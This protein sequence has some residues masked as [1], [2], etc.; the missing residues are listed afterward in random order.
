MKI[1]VLDGLVINPGD[2]SWQ[3]FTEFGNLEI[4]D[5]S[6]GEDLL[7]R[8]SDADIILINKTKIDETVLQHAK[9]LKLIVEMA[10]GFDNIDLVAAR[11]LGI[12]VTNTPGYGSSSVA[13]HAFAL[14]LELTNRVGYHDSVVKQGK[15]AVVGQFSFWDYPIMGLEGK[16]IGIIGFGRIG[17]ESAKIAKGFGMRILVNNRS[18]INETYHQVDL[19]QIYRD[20]DVIFLHCPLTQETKELIRL[21]SL[22]AMKPNAILINTSRGGLINEADLI[23]A[24]DQKMIYGAGLDVSVEEPIA[25]DSGLLRLENCIITPHIAWASIEARQRILTMCYS[26]ITNFLNNTPTHVVN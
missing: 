15:W 21:D 25:S 6:K 12:S 5:Q 20:A 17:Q 22:K 7:E 4:F 18:R 26:N 3:P 16:T 8:V 23:H 24:L 10:A 9:K 1:K 13:Q 19:E 11:A 14:L 2:L